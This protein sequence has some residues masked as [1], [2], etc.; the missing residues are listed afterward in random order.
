MTQG[1]QANLTGSILEKQVINRIKNAGYKQ[2]Q[3]KNR[4]FYRVKELPV[5][6]I[7]VQHCF[8]GDSIYGEAMK[9]DILLYHKTKYPDKLAIEIKWQQV[10]GS[11]DEKYPYLVSNIKEVFPCRAIIVIDGG[12]YKK[13][14][15]KWLKNQT[16][17]KLIGVFSLSEFL[18]WVNKGN[19]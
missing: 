16:N 10:S 5:D 3:N 7:F 4:D 9:V 11:V 6:K 17:L 8:I 1:Q 19:L 18:K 2:I 15:L 14:A 13:G 12:G